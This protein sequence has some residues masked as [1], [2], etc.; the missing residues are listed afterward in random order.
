MQSAVNQRRVT[1]LNNGVPRRILG[2][3]ITLVMWQKQAHRSLSQFWRNCSAKETKSLVYFSGLHNCKAY[4]FSKAA[5]PPFLNLYQQKAGVFANNHSSGY[6]VPWWWRREIHPGSDTSGHRAVTGRCLLVSRTMFQLRE[7][8]PLQDS[9]S[10]E[11][12]P[13]RVHHCWRPFIAVHVQFLPFMN[14]CFG[15]YPVLSLLLLWAHAWVRMCVCMCLCVCVIERSG[16][17]ERDY[18]IRLPV[19]EMWGTSFGPDGKDFAS[20]RDPGNAGDLE[21]VG[22]HSLCAQRPCMTIWVTRELD[23]DRN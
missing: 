5:F 19:T 13:S 20:P 23:Y 18:C 4:D 6:G 21:S 2:A 7:C 1:Q 9:G 10:P 15:S 11:T 3:V 8:L 22:V 12:T 16:E 14:R 17:R